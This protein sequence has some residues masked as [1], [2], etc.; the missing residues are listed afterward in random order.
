MSRSVYH[1]ILSVVWII[2]F[3]MNYMMLVFTDT[4]TFQKIE[5]A[6]CFWAAVLCIVDVIFY[7]KR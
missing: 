7:M 1:V 2:L 6:M 5:C 3:G 4:D